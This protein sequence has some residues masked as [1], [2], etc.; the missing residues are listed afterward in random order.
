MLAKGVE[1]EEKPVLVGGNKGEKQKGDYRKRR[2]RRGK[3]S[4]VRSSLEKV[5]RYIANHLKE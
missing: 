1:E 2:G 4:R 3:S 5:S